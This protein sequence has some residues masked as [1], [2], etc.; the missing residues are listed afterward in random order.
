MRE[1]DIPGSAYGD[2][3]EH[4]MRDI[5]EIMVAA[6]DDNPDIRM[7]REM[8]W[9]ELHKALAELPQ[10]QREAMELTEIK[11]L[12]VREAANLVGVNPN[13]FLSRKHYAVLHIRK[14]LRGL[15]EE[16]VVK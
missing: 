16:L 12:S 5:S 1:E 8:V 14:R 7:L 9:E 10:E 2:S 4:F 13:T 3:D 11:G 15:Y 6:D